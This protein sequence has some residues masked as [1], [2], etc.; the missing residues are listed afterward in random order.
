MPCAD[1]PQVRSNRKDRSRLSGT[2]ISLRTTVGA[3]RG[4][5]SG[6]RALLFLLESALGIVGVVLVGTFAHWF[7][8]LLPV[9]ALLSLLIVVPIALWCGFW[10]AVVVSLSAM[11]V[12]TYFTTRQVTYD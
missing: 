12:Q 6:S 8:W 2:Y 11:A 10:Q 3:R 4:R 5:R 9:A 7:Q 1:R